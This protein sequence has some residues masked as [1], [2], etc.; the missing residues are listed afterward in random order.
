MNEIQELKRER[1][2]LRELLQAAKSR[3]QSEKQ[4][5]RVQMS[6]VRW[7]NRSHRRLNASETL[8]NAQ[9]AALSKAEISEEL[10]MVE[11]SIQVQS[12]MLFSLRSQY[13]KCLHG[14]TTQLAR[15]TQVLRDLEGCA[16]V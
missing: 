9:S 4:A 5:R 13:Q 2:E 8:L 10:Q 1:A 12:K 3:N 14:M 16:L 11:S 7:M 15:G 6:C